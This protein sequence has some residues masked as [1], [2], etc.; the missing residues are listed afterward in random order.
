MRHHSQNT[1]Q[2][3]TAQH[4]WC[5]ATL[6]LAPAILHENR[7]RRRC[8]PGRRGAASRRT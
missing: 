8:C 6:Q 1:T 2:H 5:A 7:R 4:R 3:S